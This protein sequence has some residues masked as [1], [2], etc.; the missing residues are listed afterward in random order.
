MGHKRPGEAPG[1]AAGPPEPGG[2]EQRRQRSALGLHWLLE[3]GRLVLARPLAPREQVW[4]PRRQ[5]ERES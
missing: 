4:P 1:R 5:P 2:P 3:G